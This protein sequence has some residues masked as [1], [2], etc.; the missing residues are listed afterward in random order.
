MKIVLITSGIDDLSRRFHEMPGTPCAVI[1]LDS[2]SAQRKLKSLVRSALGLVFHSRFESLAGYCKKHKLRYFRVDRAHKS[3]IEAVLQQTSADLVITYRCPIVPTKYL[4]GLRFGAINLHNSLLPAFRGGDPLFWQVL[5]AVE[6]TGVTVHGLS[7]TV[8]AGPIFKQVRVKRPKHVS[9][10][11]LSHLLNVAH[12]F[13]A[14]SDT[15]E[16]LQTGGAV[17]EAQALETD[18]PS[19]PNGSRQGWRQLPQ[20]QALNADELKDVACFL[21]ESQSD[22]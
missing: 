22:Q 11:T 16:L 18:L 9:E 1:D 3:A 21:G 8:D 13:Q 2:W 4:S 20:A 10:K 14:L 7:D 17:P 5:H 19:A 12:G 6:D 15:V